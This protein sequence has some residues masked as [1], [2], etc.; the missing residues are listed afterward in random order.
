VP[1]TQGVEITPTTSKHHRQRLTSWTS[2][3]LVPALGFKLDSPGFDVRP[4]PQLDATIAKVNS[5][6]G[7]VAVS[8]LVLADRVGVGEPERRRYATRIDQVFDVDLPTHLN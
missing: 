4:E 2:A 7:H 6:P 3:G 8:L 5:G 1:V